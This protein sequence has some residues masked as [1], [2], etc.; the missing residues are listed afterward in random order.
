MHTHT[1]T[2]PRSTKQFL[3][4]VETP[5]Y[6]PSEEIG[7]SEKYTFFSISRASIDDFIGAVLP[8]I[9]TLSTRLENAMESVSG[10]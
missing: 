5:N 10:T 6:L 1:H 2:E 9:F 3:F 8:V 7:L 4:T